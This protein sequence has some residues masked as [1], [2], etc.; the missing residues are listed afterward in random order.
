M[1]IMQGLTN[2]PGVESDDASAWHGSAVP[3][4]ITGT[5]TARLTATTV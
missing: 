2:F 5:P 3:A 1:T 4:P